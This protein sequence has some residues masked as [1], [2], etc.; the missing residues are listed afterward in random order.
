MRRVAEF[1]GSPWLVKIEA[2]AKKTSFQT[3]KEKPS[4]PQKHLG[5]IFQEA[6]ADNFL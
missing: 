1:P 3:M 4:E 2:F 5:I 6:W